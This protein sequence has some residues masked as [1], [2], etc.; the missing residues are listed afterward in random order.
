MLIRYLSRRTPVLSLCALGDDHN[1]VS[2][3][4]KKRYKYSALDRFWGNGVKV[5]LLYL[6]SVRYIFSP[7]YVYLDK[8]ARRKSSVIIPGLSDYQLAHEMEEKLAPVIPLPVS[9]SKFSAPV[10]SEYPLNVF[11]AWQ[12]GKE[13][14]KGNDVLDRMVKRYISEFGE[15]KVKYE[16]VSGLTYE[17]Y[18][19]KYT[20]ADIILDQIYSYDRGMTGVLGMAAGKVVFSGFE[21]GHFEIGVNATP[22][23]NYLYN[24]FVK[25]IHSLSLVDSIKKNAFEYSLR[26]HDSNLVAEQYLR[27]WGL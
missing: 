9:P 3:C 25:T 18:L 7:L 10:K 4:A 14:R 1:W 15:H 8:Y 11:H 6:Y 21:E 12:A 24:D 27:A 13:H 26:N 22:N 16:I 23:E 20:R 19:K 17:E 5:K 2:A